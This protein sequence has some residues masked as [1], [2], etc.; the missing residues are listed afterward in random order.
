MSCKQHSIDIAETDYDSTT[1]ST[2]LLPISNDSEEAPIDEKAL[3]DEI[4]LKSENYIKGL[5]FNLCLEFV[6]TFFISAI[7]LMDLILNKQSDNTQF[8]R[9]TLDFLTEKTNDTDTIKTAKHHAS[10]KCRR[11]H[12]KRKTLHITAICLGLIFWAFG[13]KLLIQN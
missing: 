12:Q 1:S 3:I 7:L 8:P 13:L 6:E 9:D 4:K 2:E 10:L 11:A 5:T